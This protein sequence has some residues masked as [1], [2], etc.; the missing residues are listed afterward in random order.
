MKKFIHPKNYRLIIFKDINNNKLF[1]CKSTIKT[2]D[3]L[4]LNN[5]KYPLYKIEISSSSHPFYT[6]KLK[7]A[8][9]EGR[10][11][12]FNKKYK[13]YTTNY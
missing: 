1:F 12:K 4:I 13:Y 10:I 7:F 2:T 5:I 6:G 8:D 11:E 9:T 3:F